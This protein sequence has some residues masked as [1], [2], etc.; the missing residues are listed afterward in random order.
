MIILYGGSFN[1]PT[2]AHKEIIEVLLKEYEPEKIIIMP[3][4]KKYTRKNIKNNEHRLEMLKLITKNYSNVLVSDYELKNDF[5]GTI[6]TLNYLKEKY[7]KDIYL[8]IGVD[9]LLEIK[10]WIKYDELVKNYPIICINRNGILDKNSVNAISKNLGAQIDL[11]NLN[12]QVSSTNIR[13]NFE[14]YKKDVPKEILSYIEK[15]NLYN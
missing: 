13:N 5:L 6:N 8:V 1:P 4:G 3:V 12:I 11:I 15:H 14:K 7:K 9:N 10:T 2:V